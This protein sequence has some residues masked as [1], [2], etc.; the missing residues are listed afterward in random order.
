ME[1][2]RI[3]KIKSSRKENKKTKQ[4]IKNTTSFYNK[5][6]TVNSTSTSASVKR[7]Q[8]RYTNIAIE[9]NRNT[10]GDNRNLAQYTNL[11]KI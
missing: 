1:N 10:I 5:K 8:P 3:I 7:T 4:I 2:Y 6:G 9:H 11:L